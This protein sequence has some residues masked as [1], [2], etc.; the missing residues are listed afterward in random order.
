[1]AA[2][3]SISGLW[4]FIN[5]NGEWVISPQFLDAKSFNSDGQAVVGI[6]TGE[7]YSNDDYESYP[8]FEYKVINELG[9]IIHD[10]PGGRMYLY[11]GNKALAVFDE[12]GY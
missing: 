9:E 6:G 12:P 4:G 3:E 1:M 5:M 8:I 2:K 11:Y 7:E 10:F